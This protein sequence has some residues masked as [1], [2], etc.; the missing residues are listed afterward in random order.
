MAM[1]VG[2]TYDLIARG[3]KRTPVQVA[4]VQND[5]ATIVYL[6]NSGRPHGTCRENELHARD[7]KISKPKKEAKKEVK[8]EAV[9]VVESTTASTGNDTSDATESG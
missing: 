8:E 9:A 7:Q 6:D 1:K 2:E 3:G 4:S 5:I